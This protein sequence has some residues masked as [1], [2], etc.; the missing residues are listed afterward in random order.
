MQRLDSRRRRGM[1]SPC[2]ARTY[3]VELVILLLGRGA[4]VVADAAFQH[5]RWSK[6]L[7]VAPQFTNV[8]VVQCR[9]DA[10]IALRRDRVTREYAARMRT[11]TS[12]P[13]LRP[14]TS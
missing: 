4:S 3:S 8:V 9:T 7:E 5:D 14:P 2:A 6:I 13:P 10:A 12:W 1:R 11:R